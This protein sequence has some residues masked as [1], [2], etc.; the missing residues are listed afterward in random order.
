[1]PTIKKKVLRAN[2]ATGP[3]FR[4]RRTAA[5]ISGGAVCVRTG[6]HRSRLSDLERGYAAPSGDEMT[7]LEGA[8]E[9]LIE[10]RRRVA[11]VAAEV[12]WPMG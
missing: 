3:D 10:A 2:L 7:R 8:L 9:E 12:G 11:E 1:M 6:V 5:G 4:R